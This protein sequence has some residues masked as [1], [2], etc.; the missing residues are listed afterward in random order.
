MEMQDRHWIFIQ[1]LADELKC[2]VIVPIYTL[3]PLA[4]GTSCI[5]TCIELLAHLERDD[6]RYRNKHFV[7]TGDSAGGWIALRILLAL[8]ERH[9]GK[10]TS[11]DRQDKVH[12]SAS[13]LEQAG[14]VDYKAILDSIS[15]VLMISPVVDSTVDRPEDLEAEQRVSP[16]PRSELDPDP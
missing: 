7:L 13:K 14:E 4:T 16:L 3:A 1:K 5:Q 12:V 2:D 10:V 8:V 6:V 9:T 15:D 11:R